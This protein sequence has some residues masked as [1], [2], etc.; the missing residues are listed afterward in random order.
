MSQ[1]IKFH[2]ENDEKYHDGMSEYMLE[3]RGEQ[4]WPI[5]L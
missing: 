4:L 5:F 3:N 2:G 1:P